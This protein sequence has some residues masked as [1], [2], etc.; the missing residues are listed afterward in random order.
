MGCL[1]NPTLFGIFFDGL[2]SHL[3]SVAPHAGVQLGSGRWVPSLVYADDVVLLSWTSAVLQ[4]L[5]DGMH[6]FCQALGLTISPSKTEV[7]VFNGTASGTWH[8]G[9][10]VLPQSAS[11]KYLASSSMSQAASCQLLQSWRRMARVQQP[12]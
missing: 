3:D 2:H 5:L 1:L 4:S 11:F 10:H 12:V 9:Q 6:S 7:V 8:V